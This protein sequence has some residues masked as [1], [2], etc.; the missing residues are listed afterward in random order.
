MRWKYLIL[1]LWDMHVHLSEV[2]PRVL[3]V[4]VAAGVT[5]VALFHANAVERPE[6]GRKAL[7]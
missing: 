2:G 3:P 6:R 7:A 4:L 5:D 1:G